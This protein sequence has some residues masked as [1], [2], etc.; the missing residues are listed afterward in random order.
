MF[1]LIICARNGSNSVE[2]WMA[3]DTRVWPA[4]AARGVIESKLREW[5]GTQAT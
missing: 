1:G 5:N 2:L 4:V 3:G